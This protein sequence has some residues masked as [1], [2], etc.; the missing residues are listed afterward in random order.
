MLRDARAGARTSARFDA[1]RFRGP[2]TDLFV[3]LLDG[4]ALDL[5]HVRDRERDRAPPEPADRGGLH[6]ARLAPHRGNRAVD[7]PAGRPG[8]RRARRGLEIRFEGGKIVDVEADGDGADVIRTQLD[9][10]R[11][12]AVPR[13]GR[14]R[15]RLLARPADRARLPQ[16]ALRRERHLPHRLRQRAAD[17]GRGGRRARDPDEPRR[18]GR[19]RLRR[20]HRLHDRRP[21][22]RGRRPRRE[23]RSDADHPRRRLG[24]RR[25]RP[26]RLRS[27]AA[28]LRA[29]YA[30]ASSGGAAAGVSASAS[31]RNGPSSAAASARRRRP[32]L[33]DR[34]RA[35]ARGSRP[36]AG[37]SSGGGR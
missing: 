19:Q 24:A 17:G 36:R 30:V 37:R 32:A 3:G 29:P 8:H 11:A 35:R 23:R 15:R 31:R 1:I 18:A 16:H 9:A 22:G 5:R 4:L 21:R 2:G 20:A 25:G 33:G 34:A 6:D 13:R 7:V 12:G 10:R 14:A 26:R 28:S 27:P